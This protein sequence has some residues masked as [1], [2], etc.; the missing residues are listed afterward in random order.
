MNGSPFSVGEH[1]NHFGPKPERRYPAEQTKDRGVS[2]AS[3]EERIPPVEKIRK[4]LPELQRAQ[5]NGNSIPQNGLA[6]GQRPFGNV[7]H[8]HSDS[9]LSQCL[10]PQPV[11]EHRVCDEA[12]LEQ[13]IP[14]TAYDHGRHVGEDPRVR[15]A[16][17]KGQYSV[18]EPG[19]YPTPCRPILAIVDEWMPIG[20]DRL[21]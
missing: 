9:A 13:R 11:T 19:P 15:V 7:S 4:S 14:C 21:R 16:N 20:L 6:H 3:G 10:A 5:R 18:Y 8:D 12:P 17:W 1:G 2:L